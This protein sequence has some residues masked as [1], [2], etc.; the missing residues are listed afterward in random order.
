METGLIYR[1]LR[2][3]NFILVLLLILVMQLNAQYDPPDNGFFIRRHRGLY[4]SY[5]VGMGHTNTERSKEQVN[6][7]L[8]ALARDSI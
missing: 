5:S 3:E 4:V 2:L 1:S 8:P 6:Q 7:N